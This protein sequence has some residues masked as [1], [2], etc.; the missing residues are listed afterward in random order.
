MCSA[1]VGG[2]YTKLEQQSYWTYPNLIAAGLKIVIFSGDTDAAVPI[3]GTL[4]WIDLLRKERN[5]GTIE[6]WRP[7]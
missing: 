6:M 3:T 2:N 7:W 5:L 4:Y 1:W